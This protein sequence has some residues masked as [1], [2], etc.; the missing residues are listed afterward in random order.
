MHYETNLAREITLS[1]G[2]KVRN[3]KSIPTMRLLTFEC[4]PDIFMNRLR[5]HVHETTGGHSIRTIPFCRFLK[6]YN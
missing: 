6:G 5:P 1:Q 4:P 2:G 3:S